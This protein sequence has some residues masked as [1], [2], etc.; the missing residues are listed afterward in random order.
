MHD[1]EERVGVV[2]AR[3]A[4]KL[5]PLT[6]LSGVVRKLDRSQVE[7]LAVAY[8]LAQTKM[9]QRSLVARVERDSQKHVRPNK[10][11]KAWH[12]WLETPEGASDKALQLEYARIDAEHHEKLVQS[13]KHTIDRYRDELRMEWTDELLRSDFSLGDGT[14]VTWG[15][16]T[17]EQHEWRAEMHTK[18]AAAGVEG[19][20]RHRAAIRL[21]D[22][23][24]ANSL[25][26]HLAVAMEPAI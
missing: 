6:Y 7:E 8:L 16:A 17:R 18:N 13:M 19:A 24:G 15:D 9:R 14:K 5:S 3:A 21:L 20:A 1:L 4:T 25:N 12:A 26:S 22:E 23:S 2:V 10:G 11:T